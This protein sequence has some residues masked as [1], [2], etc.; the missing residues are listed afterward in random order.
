MSTGD[1]DTE[2]KDNPSTQTHL[3]RYPDDFVDA[4]QCLINDADGGSAY[5]TRAAKQ[6]GVGHIVILALIDAGLVVRNPAPTYQ[7]PHSG[8]TR[9]IGRDEYYATFQGY[10]YLERYQHRRRVWLQNNWFP[11]TVA[12]I[13]SAIGIAHVAVAL[14]S[15]F[16]KAS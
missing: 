15:L 4:L 11:V 2:E 5:F 13:T 10:G 1:Y 16:S 12:A 8:I 3:P 14:A 6:H 9:R 7:D